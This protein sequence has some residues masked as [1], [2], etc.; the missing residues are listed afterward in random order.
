MQTSYSAI[1]TILVA[2][3][4]TYTYAAPTNTFHEIVTAPPTPSHGA[5][6]LSFVETELEGNKCTCNTNYDCAYNEYCKISNC[7]DHG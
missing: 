5:A 3:S 7:N 6:A 1:A 2:T 4:T